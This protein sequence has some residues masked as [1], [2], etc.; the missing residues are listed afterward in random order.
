MATIFGV[1]FGLLWAQLR[2]PGCDLVEGY[3]VTAN[4]ERITLAC[5]RLGWRV[6]EMKPWEEA[7]DQWTWFRLRR[8]T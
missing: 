8:V 4:Q 3:F 6:E 2:D 1:D 5:N 7:P